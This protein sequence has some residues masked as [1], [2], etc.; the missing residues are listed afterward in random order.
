MSCPRNFRHTFASFHRF[1]MNSSHSSL[2]LRFLK[3]NF[4]GSSSN[5]ESC[6]YTDLVH[7]FCFRMYC[8]ELDIREFS[9]WILA[10]RFLAPWNHT[11]TATLPREV[12]KVDLM[13]L[14]CACITLYEF[15]LCLGPCRGHTGSSCDLVL[16]LNFIRILFQKF[17][18]LEWFQSQMK[19][20]T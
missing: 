20:I 2:I 1:L 4:Y 5:T 11:L 16:V 17:C 15:I 7:F 9:S 6:I 14:A 12:E 18:G 19:K 13:F 3:L 8:T 10:G